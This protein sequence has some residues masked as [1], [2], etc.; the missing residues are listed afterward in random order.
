MNRKPLTDSRWALVRRAGA[1]VRPDRPAP[2]RVAADRPPAQGRRD[3]MGAAHRLAATRP[4]PRE[5][6]AIIVA[7]RRHTLLP[8]DDCPY[9]LQPT[10]LR[11]TRSSLHRCLERH[12]IS[13]LP[14]VE[15]DK[16]GRRRLATCPVGYFRVDPAG[17]QTGEGKLRPFV[18]IDRTSKFASVRLLESASEME[19]A[20][21]LRAR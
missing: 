2:G 20:Q 14:E 18:A 15:G 8:P 21:V 5:G 3:P 7:F 17:V 12:G 1:P 9:G 10:I 6:E 11:L 13:R 4:A 19:A 16:P